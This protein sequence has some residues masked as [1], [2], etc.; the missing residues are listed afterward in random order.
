VHG[1]A[2]RMVVE[3]EEGIMRA[4]NVIPGGVNDL[5]SLANPFRPVKVNSKQHYGDQI[6]LWLANEYRPQYIFWEDVTNV[7]ESR[8]RFEP[9]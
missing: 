9:R 4:Y 3:L 6:P 8:I 7:A 2:M 5:Q 1:P